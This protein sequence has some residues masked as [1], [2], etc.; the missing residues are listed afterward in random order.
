MDERDKI[1]KL[2]EELNAASEAYYGGRE[3]IMSNFEWDAKFDELQSLE[4]L[5]GYIL[6]ES[7]TRKVSDSEEQSGG[8]KE[9]HEY[10]ALSLASH[11]PSLPP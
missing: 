7:P 1:R 8:Q 2:V 5:T 11:V 3:E 10:P 4:E 6:P 9:H